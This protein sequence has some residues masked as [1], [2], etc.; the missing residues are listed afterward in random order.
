MSKWLLYPVASTE[1]F[2]QALCLPCP[3]RK[4]WPRA[5]ELLMLALTAPCLVNNAIILDC[6]KL[7]VLVSLIHGGE[8]TVFLSQFSLHQASS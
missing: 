7:Y 1:P 4:E 6:Y 3:G 2:Y 5:L 8:M